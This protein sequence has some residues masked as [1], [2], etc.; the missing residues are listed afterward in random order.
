MLIELLARVS[1]YELRVGAVGVGQWTS[2]YIQSRIAHRT[3]G[4]AHC[5]HFTIARG[6]LDRREARLQSRNETRLL[7]QRVDFVVLLLE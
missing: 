4:I 6:R 3:V 2:D 7:G 1:T 5:C